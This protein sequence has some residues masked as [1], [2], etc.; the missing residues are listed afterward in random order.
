MSRPKRADKAPADWTP[1]D[2][3][4]ESMK[5]VGKRDGSHDDVICG[6]MMLAALHHGPRS[7]TKLAKA[8]GVEPD[9]IQWMHANLQRNGIFTRRKIR[10]RWFEVDGGLEFLLDVCCETGIMERSSAA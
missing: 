6:A 3:I 1:S 9:R 2:W 10:A 4:A 7:V 5:M 8:I